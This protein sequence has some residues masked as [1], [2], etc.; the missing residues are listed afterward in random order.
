MK[1]KDFTYFLTDYLSRYL[2]GE[3]GV[4]KNTIQS[5][6]DTFLLIMKYCVHKKVSMKNITLE[7]LDAKFFRVF[8]DWL[9]NDRKCSISTRNQRL[10]AIHAFFRYMQFKN[11]DFIYNYQEIISIPLKKGTVKTINYLTLDAIKQLFD[12]IDTKT[13]SGRRDLVLLSLMYD[14]GARVQEIAN[15]IVEDIRLTEPAT[16]KLFGKGNKY[17]IVPLMKKVS[18][19]LNQYIKENNLNHRECNKEILFKNKSGNKLTRAGINYIIKKYFNIAVKISSANFPK[20]ISAH[21]F[22]HSKA[23]HLLQAN[24]NLIYIRDLLGHV[25]IQTTEIY[26]RTDSNIKR[27]ALEK[28]SGNEVSDKIPKW[29]KNSKLMEW[30]KELCK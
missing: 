26:A 19:L 30:L 5:Y 2:P 25:N 1:K 28:A 4:S 9:E 23:M 22:R 18:K 13:N 27:K 17:R 11:P 7:Y 10:A 6:R 16:L 8:L 21:V 24:V 15:L 20:N 12:C 3:I 14:S 29:Q